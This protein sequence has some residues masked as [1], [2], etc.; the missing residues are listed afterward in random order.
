M[1]LP[2]LE[3]CLLL[4][5]A[6]NGIP[7]L[8]ESSLPLGREDVL[9][10]KIVFKYETKSR[11]KSTVCK[12]GD[13]FLQLILNSYFQNFTIEKLFFFFFYGAL[14]QENLK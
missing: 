4:A 12:D 2:V 11:N 6:G 13:D 7:A 14:K 3:T 9:R 1:C 8:A 10:E 5:T